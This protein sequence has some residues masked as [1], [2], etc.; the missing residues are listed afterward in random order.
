[1]AVWGDRKRRERERVAVIFRFLMQQTSG[2]QKCFWGRGR[3]G[4][5]DGGGDILRHAQSVTH[6]SPVAATNHQA[7]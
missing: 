2:V 4:D 3:G 6:Y 1:M 5:V 7:C